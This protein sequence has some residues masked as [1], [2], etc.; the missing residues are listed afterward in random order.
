TP[1]ASDRRRTP[2]PAPSPSG[3]A[4]SRRPIGSRRNAGE[5][6]QSRSQR[7]PVPEPQV[8]PSRPR[9]LC[10]DNPGPARRSSATPASWLFR[11]SRN[12]KCPGRLSRQSSADSLPEG[13]AVLGVSQR[14]PL[15]FLER[16]QSQNENLCSIQ[17]TA[18]QFETHWRS[19][20]EHF[21]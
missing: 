15:L 19:F 11:P 18:A 4:D 3:H 16:V 21:P 6:R 2:L 8:H 17:Y 20:S 10:P 7:S 5:C 12:R 9:G 1:S 14:L 13:S